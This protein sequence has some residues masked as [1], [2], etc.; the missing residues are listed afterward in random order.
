MADDGL[1][2]SYKQRTAAPAT[3][4]APATTGLPSSYRPVAAPAPDQT[5]TP[6]PP[7]AT[8][9]PD[10]N[11]SDP[12]RG[13]DVGPFHLGFTN[14][15]T[16]GVSWPGNSWLPSSQTTHDVQDRLTNNS[17]FNAADPIT[18]AAGGGDLAT[19]RAQ[20]Q[21]MDDQMSTAGKATA[22]IG[23]QLMPQNI[24]LNRFGGPVVQGAVDRGVSSFNQGNDW[25][26]IGADTRTGGETGI[27][28]KVLGGMNPSSL[29]PIARY[30]VEKIPALVGLKMGGDMGSGWL[31]DKLSENFVKPAAEK[32]GAAFGSIPDPP[33][34]LKQ[35][36]QQVIVGGQPAASQT[37]AGKNVGG[38]VAHPNWD[39]TRTALGNLRGMLP[40]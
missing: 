7:P 9:P 24:L 26:T 2:S 39:A 38:L 32:V 35:A 29:G 20:R 33:Q 17:L 4:P 19:L 16:P 13:F 14:R 23:A 3:T 34:W 25:S 37:D 30:G 40:F 1:P 18:A 31:A 21:K 15:G 10:P 22:D 11:A 12:N 5:V 27:A 8:A 6:P 28:A 36:V